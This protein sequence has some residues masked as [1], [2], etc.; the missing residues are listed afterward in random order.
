MLEIILN[1]YIEGLTKEEE[2][3]ILNSHLWELFIENKNT[4]HI[5]NELKHMIYLL[6]SNSDNIVIPIKYKMESKL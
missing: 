3:L 1:Q 6:S 5:K 2:L 4:V